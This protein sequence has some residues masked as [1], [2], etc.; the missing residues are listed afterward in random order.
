MAGRK[1]KSKALDEPTEADAAADAAIDAGVLPTQIARIKFAGL[2]ADAPKEGTVSEYLDHYT[3]RGV[4]FWNPMTQL[5]ETR[6]AAEVIALQMIISALHGDK[7]ATNRLIE[8]TEGKVSVST[9][10]PAKTAAAAT[11]REIAE[12]V[13]RTRQA[14]LRAARV[15]ALTDM[16]GFAHSVMV[17]PTSTLSVD[18]QPNVVFAN[19]PALKVLTSDEPTDADKIM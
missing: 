7:S 19:E 11:T 9:P 2:D 16:R 14:E 12:E 4:E 18:S 10:T 8:R 17:P 6:P 3:R 13:E 1:I 15:P 5:M